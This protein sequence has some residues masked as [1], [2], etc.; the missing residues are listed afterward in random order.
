MN[1]PTVT[2]LW[3]HEGGARDERH[4]SRVDP[5]ER[6]STRPMASRQQRQQVLT[7]EIVSLCTIEAHPSY[8]P[9][10]LV[11][12]LQADCIASISAEHACS[13]APK[14]ELLPV[15]L[16]DAISGA[17]GQTPASGGDGG[18]EPGKKDGEGEGAVEAGGGSDAL[19]GLQVF[20]LPDDGA[21][22]GGIGG[23]G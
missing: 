23:A 13:C 22:F 19:V 6:D 9:L 4:T 17:T 1:C 16:R 12:P 18:G 10:E 5:S 20:G 7:D 21:P 15:S 14:L 8:G 2:L 11:S 3:P